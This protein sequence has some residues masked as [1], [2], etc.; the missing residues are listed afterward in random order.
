M[1]KGGQ[2]HVALRLWKKKASYTLRNKGELK[3]ASRKSRWMVEKQKAR[4]LW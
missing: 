1:S 3:M 4:D 2:R